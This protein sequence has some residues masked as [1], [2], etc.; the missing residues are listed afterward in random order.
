MN[1]P[2]CPLF[3]NKSFVPLGD[4]CSFDSAQPPWIKLDL[5]I[6][7][8]IAES[9]IEITGSFHT[10]SS[11]VRITYVMDMLFS[12]LPGFHHFTCP[13]CA[14][15]PV[16]NGAYPK[17]FSLTYDHAHNNC[18]R[19]LLCVSIRSNESTLQFNNNN[20][21]CCSFSTTCYRLTSNH[22]TANDEFQV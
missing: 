22:C 8:S 11:V 1:I 4:S 3:S 10:L 19:L 20:F 16:T 2:L 21:C 9:S 5:F 18:I 12:S 17:R 6:C 7:G 14:E 13:I 15:L